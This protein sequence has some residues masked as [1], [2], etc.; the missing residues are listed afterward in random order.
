MTLYGLPVPCV[1]SW[2]I[3]NEKWYLDSWTDEPFP[4]YRWCKTVNEAQG[5]E[6]EELAFE[7]VSKIL[8][9]R[10]NIDIEQVIFDDFGMVFG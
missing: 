9:T 3:D 10:S 2:K 5:F 7:V 1:I 6:S 4:I 8:N